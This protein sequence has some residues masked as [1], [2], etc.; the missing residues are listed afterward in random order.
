VARYIDA[1]A[2]LAERLLQP[3]RSVVLCGQ[4]LAAGSSL[5]LQRDEQGL[6]EPRELVLPS[7][8]QEHPER[9]PLLLMHHELPYPG[10]RG[11]SEAAAR[12]VL[13][14]A[15]QAPGRMVVMLR[16][17]RAHE[18]CRRGLRSTGRTLLE[19]AQAP[20]A[21]LLAEFAC[22]EDAILLCSPAWWLGHGDPGLPLAGV[23]L[24]RLPF[25][26]PDHPVV[27]AMST[28]DPRWFGRWG[29]PRAVLAFRRLGERPSAPAGLPWFLAVL[30][31]RLVDK[32]YGRFF[33][34]SLPH[35]RHSLILGELR[36][37]LEVHPHDATHPG[38]HP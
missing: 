37:F 4:V 25:D 12:A 6:V 7:P 32:P 17:P 26:R 31:R 1:G 8:A 21:E 33:L 19:Q 35:R 11:W 10:E 18:L 13:A 34:R 38:D 22:C 20:A 9:Q 3:A 16:S 24:D 28:R 29:L 36:G 27:I 15:M 2:A 23:V 14:M 5:A 30:D